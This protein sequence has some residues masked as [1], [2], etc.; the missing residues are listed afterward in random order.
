MLSEGRKYPEIERMLGVAKSTIAYH[1]EKIGLR[2]H[3]FQRNEYDWGKVQAFHDKGHSIEEVVEKFGMSRSSLREARLAGKIITKRQGKRRGVQRIPLGAIFR[4]NSPYCGGL[5]RRYVKRE[6][7]IVEACSNPSC[8]LFDITSPSWA[9]RS[10]VL[11]LDHKNGIR[12][13]HRLENL[14]WLCPNCHSQTD[15]YCGRG[16]RKKAG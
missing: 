16:K 2:K 4:E 10:L 13:D 11:Q 7:L 9:E 3:T 5:A 8:A 6:R 1:A 15:T 12:N 14:R